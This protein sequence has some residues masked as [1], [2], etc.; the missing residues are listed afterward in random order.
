[1]RGVHRHLRYSKRGCPGTYWGSVRRS[2]RAAAAS[3]G[4]NLTTEQADELMVA[5]FEAF[6]ENTLALVPFDPVDG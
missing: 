6:D 4:L 2:V 1:M 3:L 5:L